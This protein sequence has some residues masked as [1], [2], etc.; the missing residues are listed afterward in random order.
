V[1][2]IPNGNAA[3]SGGG[4]NGKQ[5]VNALSCNSEDATRQL[6]PK[7]YSPP[8]QDPLKQA[9][10]ANG[11]LKINLRR[12][13]RDLVGPR[14]LATTN[15]LLDATDAIGRALSWLGAIGDPCATCAADDELAELGHPGPLTVD[16]AATSEAVGVSQ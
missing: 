10:I 14:Q 5:A 13:R 15:R 1:I 9:A 2:L 4:E 8:P 11:S 6:P 16:A 12:L 3:L 7:P